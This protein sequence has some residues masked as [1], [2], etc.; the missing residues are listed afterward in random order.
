MGC[1]HVS[2]EN[3]PDQSLG[4]SSRREMNL[5]HNLVQEFNKDI[6]E[7]YI[8]WEQHL[9]SAA[10]G[11]TV[12]KCEKRKTGEHFAIKS[13]VFEKKNTKAQK[14]VR[15]MLHMEIDLLRSLDHPNIIRPYQTY[16]TD[17]EFH[18]V[19]E[20]CTGLDLGDRCFRDRKAREVVRKLCNV[21]AY[22]HSKGICHRDLKT[23]N[24]LFDNEGPDGEIKLIDFGMS[25]RFVEGL[26]MSERLGT[27]YCMAPEV[28]SGEYTEKCDM[29]SIGVIT[30]KMLTGKHPFVGDTDEELVDNMVNLRWGWPKKPSIHPDAKEFVGSLLKLQPHRRWSANRALLAPWLTNSPYDNDTSK[31]ERLFQTMRSRRLSGIETGKGTIWE[32]RMAPSKSFSHSMVRAMRNYSEY[33]LL[34]RTALM[35]IAYDLNPIRIRELRHAFLAF[36]TEMNGVITK[37]ELT[38]ALKAM[39]VKDDEIEVF[40][41]SMDHGRDGQINYCEFLAATIQAMVGEGG[42]QDDMLL[43]LFERFDSDSSGF[44]SIENLKDI[45]GETY[46]NQ[47]ISAIIKEADFKKNGRVDFD[48][49]T[50]LMKPLNEQKIDEEMIKI[51]TIR[52]NLETGTPLPVSPEK[53]Q[54]KLPLS[55]SK[56]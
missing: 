32:R 2:K 21:I 17:S 10:M 47:D 14:Q 52:E 23:E 26:A 16:E 25:R 4:G 33:G 38:E 20:L 35:M 15:Q 41:Q 22:V 34:Q 30:F 27:P 6:N 45:L 9:G 56:T 31:N 43:A 1:S 36:D 11:C 18:L 50:Q 48:E 51:K 54:V 12:R 19:M 40:F 29:W 13:F 44:I 8:I 46:S 7:D 53:V 3:L 37:D 55:F 5:R 24:I 39:K 28:L 49:F 42:L